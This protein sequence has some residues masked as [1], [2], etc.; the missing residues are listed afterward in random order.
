MATE[1]APG[2]F[3]IRNTITGWVYI[4]SASRSI[5]ESWRQIGRDLDDNR[6][7]NVGLQM[8]W[9]RY[10]GHNFSFEVLEAV[11]DTRKLPERE[12]HW[13]ALCVRNGVV[14]Y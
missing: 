2:I 9:Q 3:A 4:G 8:D 13:R 6:H 14:L 11:T 7:S 5:A 10:S 1:N 12:Q